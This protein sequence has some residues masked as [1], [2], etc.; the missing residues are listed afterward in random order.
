MNH[1][2]YEEVPDHPEPPADLTD[3]EFEELYCEPCALCK[4]KPRTTGCC[5]EECDAE[6]NKIP[7][8][9]DE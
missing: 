6:L 9:E 2:D 7:F 8:P 5:C 3:A 1:P 4:I